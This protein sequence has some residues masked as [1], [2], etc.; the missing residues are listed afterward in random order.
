MRDGQSVAQ[1]RDEPRGE[2][3]HERGGARWS[4]AT[5]P[6]STRPTAYASS[7]VGASTTDHAWCWRS[8]VGQ[9]PRQRRPGPGCVGPRRGG[10]CAR[11]GGA[12]S[13]RAAAA[14]VNGARTSSRP[15]PDRVVGVDGRV[16]E[17]LGRGR[18][19]EA[20]AAAAPRRLAS[21]T[22]SPPLAFRRFDGGGE[23][24]RAGAA[25]G[26]VLL[27]SESGEHVVGVLRAGRRA[28]VGRP[29]ASRAPR[30]ARGAA[31]VRRV[32]RR[33]RRPRRAPRFELGEQGGAAPLEVVEHA[34]AHRRGPG[35]PSRALRRGDLLGVVEQRG[36]AVV[37]TSGAGELSS[38][39]AM[40]GCASSP[41]GACHPLDAIG[42]T[43]TP[44]AAPARPARRRDG[45]GRRSASSTVF[46][47]ITLQVWGGGAGVL[48][49]PGWDEHRDGA[50]A[51][52]GDRLL[53]DTA[54]LPDG[55]VGVDGAGHR[56]AVTAGHV[57]RR[58]R[59]R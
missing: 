47:G 22:A 7:M 2:L 35:R 49:L 21:A 15:L 24:V 27:G 31:A 40:S 11:L 45:G 12:A 26:V 54:D 18:G 13:T 57:A 32:R 56:D 46:T 42:Q 36:G 37:S 41:A 16:G 53:G 20:P 43:A 3:G 30:S 17:R 44:K 33:A 1:R 8:E 23:P 4:A 39:R 52:R 29:P 51:L 14:S 10:R 28:G 58:Q 48:L 25:G 6:V 38:G 59:R 19:R 50:A 9:Q 5:R 55:A 34:L